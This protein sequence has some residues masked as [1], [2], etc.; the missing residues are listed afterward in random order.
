[1]E[2]AAAHNMDVALSDDLFRAA[3]LA[4]SIFE[5]GV[6][7][8]THQTSIRGRTG[9]IPVWLWRDGKAKDGHGSGNPAGAMP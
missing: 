5:S 9:T 4:C 8:G 6:L 1:M 3:G 7:E 2:I